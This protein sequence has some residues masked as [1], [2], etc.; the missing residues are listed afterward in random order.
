MKPVIVAD[1]G[2]D[3]AYF[4]LPY[5]LVMDR[6]WLLATCGPKREENPMSEP[7]E[8][9]RDDEGNVCEVRDRTNTTQ[10]PKVWV[11]TVGSS[12]ERDLTADSVTPCDA[13]GAPLTDAEPTA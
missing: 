13:Q 6:T 1:L 3:A 7:R 9:V 4:D 12:Y 10:G 5:V 8:Y 2:P 11:R